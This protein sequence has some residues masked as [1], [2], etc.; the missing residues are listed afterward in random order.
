MGKLHRTPYTIDDPSGT[1]GALG[2]G[3]CRPYNSWDQRRLADEFRWEMQP[4]VYKEREWDNPQHSAIIQSALFQDLLLARGPY[5]RV[6]GFCLQHYISF[7]LETGS[8]SATLARQ[9]GV[10]SMYL[11]SLS[12]HL[13]EELGMFCLYLNFLIIFCFFFFLIFF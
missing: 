12:I 1:R 9:T 8:G 5:T 6:T 3:Y 2:Y 7:S 13:E 10:R 4:F 11:L